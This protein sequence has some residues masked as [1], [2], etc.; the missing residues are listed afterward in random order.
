VWVRLYHKSCVCIPMPERACLAHALFRAPA[1]PGPLWPCTL[2]ALSACP[3]ICCI[4]FMLCNNFYRFAPYFCFVLL[5]RRYGVPK[6]LYFSFPVTCT[7]GS[8]S[9]VKGLTVDKFSQEVS[10]SLRRK[11]QRRTA[12]CCNWH[13]SHFS[14][15]EHRQDY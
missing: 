2:T 10:C 14:S 6:G 4:R 5:A 15:A 8:Y 9:I 7:P 13:S 11:P 1:A 3:F 12:R